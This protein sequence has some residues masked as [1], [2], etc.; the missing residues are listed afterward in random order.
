MTVL[1]AAPDIDVIAAR[2][3]DAK[4]GRALLT[5][6]VAVLFGLGWCTRKFFTV[7]WLGGAWCFFAVAE[8]W[9][10]AAPPKVPA[11]RER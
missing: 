6:I 3:R 9:R 1:T 7:L 5:L 10:A 2:A 11:R 8:G 4:P